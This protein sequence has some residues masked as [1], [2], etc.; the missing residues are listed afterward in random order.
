MKATK[1]FLS[2]RSALAYQKNEMTQEAE[3]H[4]GLR[5]AQDQAE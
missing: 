5:A 3:K 2:R 4:Q 1:D